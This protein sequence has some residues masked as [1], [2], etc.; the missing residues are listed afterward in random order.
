MMKH[1]CTLRT[2]YGYL[3]GLSKA[4][5]HP[6]CSCGWISSFKYASQ[7]RAL[8]VHL[9]HVTDKEAK[10]AGVQAPLPARKAD[11][12]ECGVGIAKLDLTPRR[13]DTARW[14]AEEDLL[15]EDVP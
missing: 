2:E 10:K 3:M 6:K 1:E 5:F 12:R 9:E 4:W 7:R 8:D 15:C 11:P 13:P 14:I